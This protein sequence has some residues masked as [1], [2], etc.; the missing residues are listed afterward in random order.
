MTDFTDATM[1][2][3]IMDSTKQATISGN[4]I[5]QPIATFEPDHLFTSAIVAVQ[6]SST[7]AKANWYKAGYLHQAIP[8]PLSLGLALGESRFIALYVPVI[9]KFLH[10]PTNYKISFEVQKYF[11]DCNFKAWEFNG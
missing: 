6:I 3:L 1:W 7:T 4:E 10:F 5:I 8:V 2:N 9:I 11:K